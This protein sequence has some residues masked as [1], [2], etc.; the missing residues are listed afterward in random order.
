[1]ITPVETDASAVVIE[2]S[3][4]DIINRYKQLNLVAFSG[5]MIELIN[6]NG[7]AKKHFSFPIGWADTLNWSLFNSNKNGHAIRTGI[8]VE[9]QYFMIPLDIENKRQTLKRFQEN[10]S[11]KHGLT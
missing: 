7:E 5:N 2:R 8:E 6:N 4:T 9:S 11:N 1:M 3:T 10:I